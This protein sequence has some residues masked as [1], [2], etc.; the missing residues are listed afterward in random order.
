MYPYDIMIFERWG[1]YMANIKY[2]AKCGKIDIITFDEPEICKYCNIL[3]IETKYSLDDV[4]RQGK[5]AII[6]TIEEEYIVN[7]SEFSIEEKQKRIEQDRLDRIHQKPYTPSTSVKCP[8]CRSGDVKKITIA[9]RAVSVGVFGIASG[10]I[11]KQ[12]HCNKCKS[13]F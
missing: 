6:K 3:L 5:E 2:C 4:V 12:W 1:L 8:Y 13:D 9:G 11:G 10:K 7:N